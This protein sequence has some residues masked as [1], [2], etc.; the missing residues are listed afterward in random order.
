MDFCMNS[1]ILTI[2]NKD[3]LIDKVVKSIFDNTSEKFEFIVVYDGCND[4]SQNIVESLIQNDKII[5]YKSLYANDV[6]ETKS[7]NMAMKNSTGD[8]FII[9]QDDMIIDEKN[10]DNRI[11]LPYEKY[12]DVFA[13][14]ARAAHNYSPRGDKMENITHYIDKNNASRD[15][16]YIRNSVNRGP[17]VLSSEMTKKLNYLDEIFAPYTWDDHDICYRAYNNYKLVSGLLVTKIISETSW[18]TTRS[19]N[20]DL[21]HKT[22][23][24]NAN[25]FYERHKNLISINHNEERNIKNN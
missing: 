3:W 8:F 7:N 18:G 23:F 19:K 6:F 12:N 11:L 25:I 4:N 17:L 24:R 14:S 21:F 13:V 16:F 5:E 9:I 2:H 10:W 22:N 1:I 15:I 20:H